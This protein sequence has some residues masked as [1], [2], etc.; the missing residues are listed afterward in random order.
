[1]K[2]NIFLLMPL[3]LLAACGEENVPGPQ[4]GGGKEPTQLAEHLIICNEGNWQSDNGQLSFYNGA[5]GTLTKQCLRYLK[6]LL[7]G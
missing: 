5:T 3:L 2:R 6:C 4:P 7:L 1:M